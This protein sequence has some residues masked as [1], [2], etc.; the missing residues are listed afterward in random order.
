MLKTSSEMNKPFLE[1][2]NLKNQ[3][4]TLKNMLHLA[5]AQWVF[6]HALKLPAYTIFSLNK[7][8]KFLHN[9]VQKSLVHLSNQIWIVKLF[10][11]FSAAEK[12]RKTLIKSKIAFFLVDPVLRFAKKLDKSWKNRLF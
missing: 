9:V 12:C 1:G 2:K 10:K 3:F 6:D 11:K 7:W 4:W 8:R 5:Q